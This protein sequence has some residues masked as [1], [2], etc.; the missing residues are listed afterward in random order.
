MTNFESIIVGAGPYGLSIAAHLRDADLN[1]AIIGRPMDSWRRYMP[2]GMALKSEYFASHLSDPHRR[3]GLDSFCGSQGRPYVRS[4]V[5]LPIEDFVR[6]ADWFRREAVPD[7][8]DMNLRNLRWDG[9]SFE[10]M[11]DDRAVTARRVIVAT[12]HI[13]Y[14]YVPPVLVP[15]AR[16]KDGLVS[17]SA[18]HRDLRRF[19][20]RDVT[21]I[22]CGQSGL[23]TAALLHEN[24]AQ[25]RLLAR[26][27]EIDW[28]PDLRRRS[29]VARFRRPESGLGPGWRSLSFAELPKFFAKLPPAKRRRLLDAAH[30]PAGAW[31]LKE[32]VV[33]KIPL[34]TSHEIAS[35]DECN[36]R[37]DL[38]VRT[39]SDTLRIETDHVI[40][41]TGYRVDLE[42]LTFLDPALRATIAVAGGVPVLNSVFECTVPGL[43][44]VGLASALSFGPVMRFVYGARHAATILTS[45]IR[46]A[47]RRLPKSANAPPAARGVAAED[48]VRQA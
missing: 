37:L 16:E 10:L 2:N 32:R 22:G 9:Q 19:S 6:Y 45:H 8:W 3:Y 14:C 21:V 30:A 33:G 12:G 47:T 7:I 26:T 23:E 46:A 20:G 35:A 17:H 13:P 15:H 25:V 5:P 11:L 48:P 41:A 34:M 1:H 28:N 36:G 39:K 29:A 24:G 42:R 31:W 27:P 4:G 44:F 40:A 43:H 18:D 38:T